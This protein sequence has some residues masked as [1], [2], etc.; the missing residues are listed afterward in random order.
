[1]VEHLFSFTFTVLNSYKS[2]TKSSANSVRADLTNSIQV[3]NIRLKTV[4]S[5]YPRKS[6]VCESIPITAFTENSKFFLIHF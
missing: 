2:E 6:R 4:C 5:A 1:M 3:E